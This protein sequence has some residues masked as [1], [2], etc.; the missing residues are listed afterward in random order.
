MLYYTQCV[1]FIVMFAFIKHSG[2]QLK[3]SKGDLIT[4]DRLADDAG[5][6]ISITDVLMTLGDDQSVS[7]NPKL[8]VLCE[9]VEHFKGDKILVVK[10]RPK[11]CYKRKKG[12]RQQYTKLKVKDIVPC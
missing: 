10:H 8:K 3:I 11:K 7:I 4:V 2:K 1:K 9:V 6:E 12:H 5:S